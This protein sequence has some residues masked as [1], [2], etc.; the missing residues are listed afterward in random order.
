MEYHEIGGSG[1]VI[2]VSPASASACL[3]RPAFAAGVPTRPPPAIHPPAAA[4]VAGATRTGA[5]RR[6]RPRRR[7]E[8]A[9]LARAGDL[10]LAERS[11]PTRQKASP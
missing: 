11:L 5:R 4:P 3:G 6:A 2:A 7:R 10:G 8:R 9:R 1:T